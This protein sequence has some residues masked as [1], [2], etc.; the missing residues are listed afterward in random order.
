MIKTNVVHTLEAALYDD[1]VT[2]SLRS[3]G[4]TLGA[5]DLRVL[6]K[7]A[8][9]QAE[10]IERNAARITAA[11]IKDGAVFYA[12]G[13]DWRKVVQ[14]HDDRFIVVDRRGRTHWPMMSAEKIVSAIEGFGYTKV[15]R[16]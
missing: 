5:E 6:A 1:S 3:F 11:D 4:C 2:L 9:D 10:R 8:D 7:W 16:A 14:V 15:K 13:T 12:G